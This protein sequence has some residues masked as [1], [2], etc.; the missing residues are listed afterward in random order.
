MRELLY[1]AI[2][3]Q[4]ELHHEQAWADEL[5]PYA[6]PVLWFGDVESPLPKIVTIGAN[7]SRREFLPNT[8]ANPQN[9]NNYLVN[10]AQRFYVLDLPL[11]ALNNIPENLLDEIINSYNNYFASNPYATWFG[12]QG[13]GKVEAFIN[14]LEASLYN[15]DKNYRGIHIDLFPFATVSDFGSIHDLC[16]QDLFQTGWARQFL[17]HLVLNINPQK[18]IVFG[19]SNYK[20]LLNLLD[21]EDVEPEVFEV[22]GKSCNIFFNYLN[23]P[24]NYQL[25]GL[26]VNLGNPHGWSRNDLIQLGEFVNINQ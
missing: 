20:W 4:Q 10:H 13:G 21:V 14:G 15:N 12:A 24:F 2:L 19:I 6:P 25:I 9:R 11:L 26:S 8:D 3:K 18:L 17:E 22:S 23:N 5:L 16:N 1:Q 7:P